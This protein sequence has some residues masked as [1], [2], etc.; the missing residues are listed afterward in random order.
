MGSTRFITVC[1]LTWKMKYFESCRCDCSTILTCYAQNGYHCHLVFEGAC[2]ISFF[3]SE[4]SLG[5]LGEAEEKRGDDDGGSHNYLVETL[6]HM[7]SPLV[8]G[9]AGYF[10]HSCR[11]ASSSSSGGEKAGVV[12]NAVVGGAALKMG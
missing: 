4:L 7:V 3:W 5:V 2:K 11:P 10:W 1:F 9:V 8:T 6:L 12:G